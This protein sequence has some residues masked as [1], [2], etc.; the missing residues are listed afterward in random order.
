MGFLYC[1]STFHC[2]GVQWPSNMYVSIRSRVGYIA[3]NRATS[4]V[5]L[6]NATLRP[7]IPLVHGV[8]AIPA[9]NLSIRMFAS[10]VDSI[11]VS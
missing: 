3:G 6:R 4:I 1:K 9:P 2:D 8:R 11:R 10:V 5:S 7:V